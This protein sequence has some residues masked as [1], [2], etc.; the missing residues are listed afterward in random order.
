M[1]RRSLTRT[2]PRASG[3][4]HPGR[5]IRSDEGSPV[6]AQPEA[7][8]RSWVLELPPGLK[9]LSLNGRL[10]W[11]ERNRRNAAIK[12]AAWACALNAKLPHLERITLLVEYQPPDRR[13][14]DADNIALAAKAALD[15]LAAAKVI[16]SD[17]SAHVVQVAY[18]IGPVYPRGRVVLH[19]T[20]LAA[21]AEPGRNYGPAEASNEQQ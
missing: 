5:E 15:G 16:P 10:H 17:D 20:E 1:P 3:E 2:P 13:P 12:K 14:R 18:R 11:A 6:S 8:P 19:I 7:A 4:L 9:L 21:L